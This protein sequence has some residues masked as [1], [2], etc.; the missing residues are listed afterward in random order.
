MWFLFLLSKPSKSDHNKQ[1]F[2]HSLVN[3]ADT[4]F[5]IVLFHNDFSLSD[6]Q[7]EQHMLAEK[8]WQPNASYIAI[9]RKYCYYANHGDVIK[10]LTLRNHWAYI[11]D[12]SKYRKARIWGMS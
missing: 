5:T 10:S 12:V 4:H 3:F 1:H 11:T 9:F 8:S 6:E 2:H 7:P